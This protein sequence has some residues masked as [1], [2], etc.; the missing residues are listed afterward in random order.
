[1]LIG[2]LECIFECIDCTCS[3]FTDGTR[4]GVSTD[5][6]EGRKALQRDLDRLDQWAEANCVCCNETQF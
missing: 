4:L 1:M 2:P 6:F 5:V 3:K